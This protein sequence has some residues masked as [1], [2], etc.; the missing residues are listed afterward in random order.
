M[1]EGAVIHGTSYSIEE[2]QE[3][4]QQI[5]NI[6]AEPTDARAV[7]Y[8]A[9]I[10][11]IFDDA[12]AGTN[13]RLTDADIRANVRE[14]GL[15]DDAL[16][17]TVEVMRL[18]HYAQLLQS[19]AALDDEQLM[20]VVGELQAVTQEDIDALEVEVNPRFGTWD[21]ANGG[22]IPEVP[23]WIETPGTN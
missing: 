15:Q 19:P 12:F 1:Q 8:E 14:A 20:P 23:S 3:S 11:Q 22:V 5:N 6:A 13:Y 18:R 10:E 9:A 2:V 17:L 7:I 21:P 4:V 16:P